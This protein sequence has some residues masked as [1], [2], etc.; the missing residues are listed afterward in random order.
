MD[1]SSGHECRPRLANVESDAISWKGRLVDRPPSAVTTR[2]AMLELVKML[3]DTTEADVNSGRIIHLRRSM[4]RR[5]PATRRRIGFTSSC[6]DPIDRHLLTG[7]CWF[8]LGFLA[9]FEYFGMIGTLSAEGA[10]HPGSRIDIPDNECSRLEIIRTLSGTSFL[11]R[12]A[13]VVFAPNFHRESG[14]A[15]DGDSSLISTTVL[16]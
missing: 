12:L 3:L 5:E 16:T 1:G 11:C 10:N 7:H 8:R 13:V 9:G 4:G 2:L 14:G 6:E 15:F